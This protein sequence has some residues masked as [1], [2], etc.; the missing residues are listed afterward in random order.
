AFFAK[1]QRDNTLAAAKQGTSPGVRELPRVG[2]RRNLPESYK[3][4]PPKFLGGAQPQLR[5]SEPLRPVLAKWLTAPD[6]PYF[7][8]ATVNRW[9]AKFFGRGLV[10]PVD[11]MHEDNP[12]VYPELLDLL[13]QQ[14]VAHQFDLKWLVRTI[15][16]TQAYQRSSK[17]VGDQPADPTLFAQMP[18]KP[19]N[20]AQLFDA[21]AQVV[22]F[23][24][25]LAAR[26]PA[27]GPKPGFNV[28]EAFIIAFSGDEG[29]DPLDYQAGIPH[30]LRLMNSPMTNADGIVLQDALRRGKS[31]EE[32]LDWLFLGVLSRRPSTQ[33]RERFLNYVAQRQYSRAAW[34]DV[35]W[36]LINSSEFVLTR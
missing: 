29:A 17:P 12:P 28:R 20:P 10:N 34:S 23:N 25:N 22:G 27:I 18:V 7:A 21:L 35:F 9:W 32:T 33:E 2:L 1:V 8:K 24:R 14:F 15:T 30:A 11:D 26:K 6:N 3:P 31:P 13:A 4:L 19:M 36:A 16:N 5:A